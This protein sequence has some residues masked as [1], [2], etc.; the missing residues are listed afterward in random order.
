MLNS[1]SEKSAATARSERKARRKTK[2]MCKHTMKTGVERE[3]CAMQG[4]SHGHVEVTRTS[5]AGAGQPVCTVQQPATVRQR[6][7][8]H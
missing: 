7:K 3:G 2:L 5:R 8:G 6:A 4:G 1:V